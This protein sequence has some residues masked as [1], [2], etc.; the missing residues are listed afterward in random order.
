[1]AN[2]QLPVLLLRKAEGEH[3][4]RRAQPAGGHTHVV[5]TLDVLGLEDAVKMGEDLGHPN[6][7]ARRR[8]VAEAGVGLESRNLA[9]QEVKDLADALG[10]RR[11]PDV[12]IASLERIAGG[13]GDD[14]RPGIEG[15]TEDFRAEQR[16]GNE[17]LAE[18]LERVREAR[19]QERLGELARTARLEAEEKG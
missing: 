18:A 2:E 16:R 11:D 14:A 7:D 3:L 13:L 5:H 1:M 4:E 12:A 17:V 6:L 10:E 8:G 19:L 9:C 15:L